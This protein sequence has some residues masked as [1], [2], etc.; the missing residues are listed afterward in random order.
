MGEGAAGKGLLFGV[1]EI[2]LACSPIRTQCRDRCIDR[3]MGDFP[4]EVIGD[5][6]TRNSACMITHR[7][8]NAR[9]DCPF[10]PGKPL[11][12]FLILALPYRLRHLLSPAVAPSS[13]KKPSQPLSSSAPLHSA[14]E[15][16]TDL[17]FWLFNS[18]T[19]HQQHIERTGHALGCRRPSYSLFLPYSCH[20]TP[21]SL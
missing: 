16:T 13:P 1:R 11:G 17:H 19:N 8:T 7:T 5:W 20:S 4:R 2:Q 10:S 21:P 14:G 15:E 3:S 18:P 12:I 6:P 9:A